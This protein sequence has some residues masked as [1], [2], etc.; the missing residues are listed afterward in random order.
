MQL[1]WRKKNRDRNSG[2]ITYVL[3]NAKVNCDITLFL[4][5]WAL[6][7]QPYES[8]V[9]LT[10]HILAKISEV[11]RFL[12]VSSFQSRCNM[13][14]HARST[15]YH[16]WFSFFRFLSQVF[17]SLPINCLRAKPQQD[18]HWTITRGFNWVIILRICLVFAYN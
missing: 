5:V 8:S 18:L 16:I 15:G 17:V 6:S 11:L 7:H 3:E 4:Q 1:H 12:S 13:S 9:F 14:L 2:I 10:L